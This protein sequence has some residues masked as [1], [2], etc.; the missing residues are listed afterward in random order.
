MGVVANGRD[1]AGAVH[2]DVA[3][4][5]ASAAEAAHAETH[6]DRSR[7]AERAGE[8]GRHASVAAAA[9]KRLGLNPDRA[10]PDG[11]DFLGG[12]EEHVAAV[13][14][15]AAEPADLQRRSTRGL[16]RTDRRPG[17]EAALAAPAA[18]G[19]GEQAWRVHA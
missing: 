12:G 5:A 1:S 6:G 3:S 17:R 11:E 14:A 15:G 8:V 9:A 4:I 10:V 2:R 7:A 19:L 13:A 18:H 16:A